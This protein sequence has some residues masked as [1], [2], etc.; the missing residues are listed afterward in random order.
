MEHGDMGLPGAAEPFRRRVPAGLRQPF[1]PSERTCSRAPAGVLAAPPPCGRRR[2]TAPPA[3]PRAP[4]PV[5]RGRRWRPTRPAAST[6][7]KRR[8]AAQGPNVW[9][10]VERGRRVRGGRVK[11]HG[12]VETKYRPGE[13]SI[14][15]GDQSRCEHRRGSRAQPSAVTRYCGRWWCG[16]RQLLRPR[17]R[18]PACHLQELVIVVIEHRVG[19][20]PA[21]L[22]RN[23]ALLSRQRPD[24]RLGLR[25]RRAGDAQGL[26]QVPVPLVAPHH[27]N[28]ARRLEPVGPARPEQ[29]GGLARLGRRRPRPRRR[30]GG[31]LA[32][33][34][35]RRTEIASGRRRRAGERQG[36]R[37]GHAPAG[38]AGRA[39]QRRPSR[40]RP[41]RAGA[42]PRRGGSRETRPPWPR[43]TAR[44]AAPWLGPPPRRPRGPGPRRQPR[45]APLPP[46][47]GPQHHQPSPLGCP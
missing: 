28:L 20:A 17:E 47:R 43:R 40:A 2:G 16:V 41:G 21:R 15:Q 45:Q 18:A 9:R 13:K 10:W 8:P 7:E 6:P 19:A 38:W 30:C 39:S 46:A 36:G 26:A 24:L 37:P 4:R 5:P 3:A 22:V 25:A 29:L 11:G 1:T 35:A 12:S 44:A 42:P 32:A 23:E 27:P 14:A 31:R 34:R 33:R